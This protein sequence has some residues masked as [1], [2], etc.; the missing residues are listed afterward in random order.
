MAKIFKNPYLWLFIILIIGFWLRLYKIDNPIADWHSWRQA[1][2]AAVARNFFKEGYN[3]ILPKYDDMSGVAEFPVPNP[4]RYRFVEFPIYPSLIYL[5]YLI[6]GAVDEKLARVINIFFSLASTIFVYLIAKRYLGLFTSVVSAL[7]FTALPFNIY[8]SRSILPESSLI[9]FCLGM[10]YFVDVWIENN[11][12]LL[13]IISIFFTA[14]AFLTKPTAAFYL[15]PHLYTVYKKE[16][17][18]IFLPKKYFVYVVFSLLPYILWRIWIS[19]HPEGIPSANWLFNGTHIRFRPAFFRWILGDRFGREILTVAGSILFFIGIII[20]PF[21]K[22]RLT[23]YL[24]AA[25]LLSYL[26][27][28]ASGNVTHDYY[29]MLIVPIL[30]IFVAKG[31]VLLLKGSEIFLP[32]LITIPTAILLFLSIFNLGWFE[33]KGLYQINNPAIVEAGRRADQ[34]LPQDAK[35]LTPYNGDTAFLYQTNRPGFSNYSYPIT[36]LRN[37][38]GIHYL[39]SV[40]FDNKTKWAMETYTILEQK[41]NYVIVDLTKPVTRFDKQYFT[42]PN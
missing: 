33:I 24:L 35:V 19:Q 40:N 13:L 9:F 31:A 36:D 22:E 16:S 21:P 3:P 32:R 28:L 26:V 15:I 12:K 23:L 30:V 38:F 17:R 42:E 20:K 7:L 6:N 4:Q 18:L 25:S 41:D 27:I 34:I 37:N 8:F 1:D 5:S 2:T 29:Q 11:T 39:V 14:C 10:F